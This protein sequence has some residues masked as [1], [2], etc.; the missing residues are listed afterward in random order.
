LKKFKNTCWIMMMTKKKLVPKRTSLKEVRDPCM[1][2]KTR[3][4]AGWKSKT[5]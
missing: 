5:W 4:V 2:S 1:I 3:T